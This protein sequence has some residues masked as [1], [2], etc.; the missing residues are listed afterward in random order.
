MEI[1]E[2]TQ[3]HSPTFMRDVF[4]NLIGESVVI[5]LSGCHTALG[6]KVQSYNG[7]ILHL[8]STGSIGNTYIPA[9]KI[10]AICSEK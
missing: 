6:G 2:H 7:A 8:T 9:D 3:E 1:L 4:Y 10:I 5:Y